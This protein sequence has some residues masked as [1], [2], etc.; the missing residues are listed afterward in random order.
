MAINQL[1]VPSATATNNTPAMPFSR[2][3][4]VLERAIINIASRCFKS[5]ANFLMYF[6]S[7]RACGDYLLDYSLT[8]SGTPKEA[9]LCDHIGRKARKDAPPPSSEVDDFWA[10]LDSEEPEIETEESENKERVSEPEVPK[11]ASNRSDSFLA[12]ELQ[13]DW[14]F[15]DALDRFR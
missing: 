5:L 7:E 2:R 15:Q 6:V 1:T 8:I 13:Q 10:I 11:P 14:D 4:S 12:E 9:F 3:T